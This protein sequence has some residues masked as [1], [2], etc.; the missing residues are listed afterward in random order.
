MI[1]PSKGGRCSHQVCFDVR[2]SV[3]SCKANCAC[4][5]KTWLGSKGSFSRNPSSESRKSC[6]LLGDYPLVL[7][8]SRSLRWFET[9]SISGT[10]TFM[11]GLAAATSQQLTHSNLGKIRRSSRTGRKYLLQGNPPLWWSGGCSQ[12]TDSEKQDGC[13]IRF[14][15]RWLI[16]SR[17]VERHHVANVA[18]CTNV[19]NHMASSLL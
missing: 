6:L 12:C 16:S 4:F 8:N 9:Y 18:S 19:S 5:V 13:S 15:L 14:R 2:N 11:F 3:M 17:S 1:P 7:W 10:C